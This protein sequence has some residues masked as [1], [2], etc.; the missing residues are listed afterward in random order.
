MWLT[1]YSNFFRSKKSH[2]SKR[3]LDLFNTLGQYLNYRKTRLL[4]YS[5]ANPA[6]PTTIVS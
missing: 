4:V 5:R 6:L 2:P 3:N 1:H